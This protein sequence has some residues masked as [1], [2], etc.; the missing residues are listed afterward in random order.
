MSKV[1][2]LSFLLMFIL[3]V[4]GTFAQEILQDGT[5]VELKGIGLDKELRND[6][7]IGAIYAPTEANSLSI[8]KDPL[9]AKRIIIRYVVD[10]YSYRKVSRHFKERI[11][12]NS[13]RE[14]WQPITRDIVLFSRLFKQN[15]V[16]GDEIKLDFIPEKGTVVSLNNVEF[17]TITNPEFMRLFINSW[18]GSVPPTKQFK[19]GILDRI[20]ATEKQQL[21]AQ[22]NSLSPVIGRFKAPESNASTTAQ[23]TATPAPAK[24]TS[25]QQAPT[26][27]VAAKTNKTT[28][29]TASNKKPANKTASNNDQS[30][31]KTAAVTKPKPQPKKVV[32][33]NSN[34]TTPKKTTPKKQPV[35]SAKDI[36]E[37]VAEE[38][39]VDED[40]I[41]GS[42]TRDLIR[43]VQKNQKYPKKAQRKGEQGEGVVTIIIDRNG[44]LIDVV[45][46][47]KTGS[48]ELDKGVKKMVRK[49]APFIPMP[50]ELKE[51]QFEFTVP[52]EF[53]L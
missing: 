50:V 9:T 32:A 29:S 52:V 8:L 31:K 23:T 6:I 43:A 28:T 49:T 27:Q 26:K 12:M 21:I 13:P 24:Q 53:K 10:N 22:L 47:E 4:S 16:R 42:Y 35:I 19:E 37:K 46:T 41:R 36:A 38:D 34:R 18:T 1:K 2:N 20:D 7:Y 33:N 48:R 5:T 39:F 11:A 14:E 15:M 3:T 17:L 30:S 40:L 45:M 51:A 44:N 25:R